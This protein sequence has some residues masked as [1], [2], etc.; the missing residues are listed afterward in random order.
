MSHKWIASQKIE[1]RRKPIA[2]TCKE[3]PDM[4]CTIFNPKLSHKK[5]R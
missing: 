1:E 2:L 4:A 5:S 3:Y